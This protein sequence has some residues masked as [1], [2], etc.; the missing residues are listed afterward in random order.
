MLC[1]DKATL[2]IPA[3]LAGVGVPDMPNE[4]LADRRLGANTRITRQHLQYV[5]AKMMLCR[6]YLPGENR[7]VN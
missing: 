4:S 6:R 3:S 5:H 2:C 7:N 1:V